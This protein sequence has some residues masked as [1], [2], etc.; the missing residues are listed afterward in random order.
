MAKGV[1]KVA[2]Y[3]AKGSKPPQI[4]GFVTILIHTSER[5]PYGALSPYLVKD[6][7]GRILENL[8]QGAK[9]YEEV[10]AVT[11]YQHPQFHRDVVYW[12]HPKERHVQ[13]NTILPAYWMWRNKLFENPYP[14]RYPN[15]PSKV[16]RGKAI[17]SIWQDDRQNWMFL[18]YIQARKKIYCNEYRRL[19]QHLPK[20]QELKQRLLN[21]ENLLIVEVDGPDPTLDFPP[22]DRISTDNPGL[23]IDEATIRMLINDPRKPFG[24]GFVIA[25]L[26]LDGAAWMM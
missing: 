21:G 20:F 23:T 6:E 18:D 15:G 3:Y 13:G 19:S 24:H 22:Y 4:P 16:N 26:L 17:C 9:I 14:V 8:W 5:D 25:A 7:H 2:K 10:Q 11:Q 1:V 12:Q